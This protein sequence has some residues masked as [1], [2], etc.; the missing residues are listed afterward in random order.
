MSKSTTTS[1]THAVLVRFLIDRYED[2][3]RGFMNAGDALANARTYLDTLIA[4]PATH[5]GQKSLAGIADRFDIIDQS[6]E[7]NGEECDGEDIGRWTCSFEVVARFVVD[8]DDAQRAE[9]QVMRI[10]ED[11][12]EDVIG[13]SVEEWAC[14][15]STDIL[16][17]ATR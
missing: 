6:I 4:K 13:D 8:A 15:W 17:N 11:A 9:K 16:R 1:T 3:G 12:I 14:N 2:T 10:V 5:R 7:D